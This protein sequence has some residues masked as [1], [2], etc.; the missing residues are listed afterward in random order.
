M[1]KLLVLVLVL[2]GCGQMTVKGNTEH[3]VVV[4]T[5]LFGECGAIQDK[6]RQDQ[7]FDAVI[8]L[9]AI[10][11]TKTEQQGGSDVSGN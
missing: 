5:D 10:L 1:N 11:A 4:K 2:T 8:N 7:C 9:M 3:D 6:V